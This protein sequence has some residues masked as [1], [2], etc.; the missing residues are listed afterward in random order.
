M[1]GIG[2]IIL[3]NRKLNF[4]EVYKLATHLETRG[5]D[6][7]GF[8]LLSRRGRVRRHFKLPSPATEVLAELEKL[9]AP[10]I[11]SSYGILMHTRAA[12]FGE[13]I[14]NRNNHPFRISHYY[15]AHNGYCSYTPLEWSQKRIQTDSF[16]G[17]FVPL[18]QKI[19]NGESIKQVVWKAYEEY[20]ATGAFWLY[21]ERLRKLYLFRVFMPLTY[22]CHTES[23]RFASIGEP[24][25]LEDGWFIEIQLPYHGKIEKYP[26]EDFKDTTNDWHYPPHFRENGKVK[27]IF[28]G[29][30]TETVYNKGAQQQSR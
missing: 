12:T 13:P 28:D 1:C 10:I 7:F 24:T 27:I 30:K 23:F 2:G 9:I 21:D 29:H 19:E 6:A 3:A 22:S 17:L 20:S 14:I 4:D 18:I 26:A 15:F 11:E 5:R 25:H 16:N 8:L